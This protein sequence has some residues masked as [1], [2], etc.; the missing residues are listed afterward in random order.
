MKINDPMSVDPAASGLEAERGRLRRLRLVALALLLLAIAGMLISAHFG[1]SGPWGWS[2][3]FCEAAAVG[4]L[5]D[6]F[7]VTALF[8]RPLGLPIPHTDV[9]AKRKQEIGNGLAD[10]VSEHFLQ[11]TQLALKLREQAFVLRFADHLVQPSAARRV[12]DHARSYALG[13]YD[14]LSGTKLESMIAEMLRTGLERLDFG[15]MT[16]NWLDLLTRDGRHHEVLD[17]FLQWL[18]EWLDD[19]DI[20]DRI[21]RN[22]VAGIENKSGWWRALNKVGLADLI[23]GEITDSL[24]AMIESLQDSLRDPAHPNREAFDEWL[25]GAIDRLQ[26]DPETQAWL[27]ERIRTFTAAP[28][29]HDYLGGIG[30]DVRGWLRAD[31]EREDSM[32]AAWLANGLSGLARR[33]QTDRELR[34]DLD[35]LI[36]RLAIVL[37]PSV[38]DFIHKHIRETV[39]NWN[40]RDLISTLE[41][42]LGPDLQFIRFNGTLA[43]GLIGLFLHALLVFTLPLLT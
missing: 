39:R 14:A 30:R 12:A 8:R 34:E 40:E 3:A 1:G 22:I 15:R 31:L 29:F 11:P 10:F 16:G 24:P 28:E 42:K 21:F 17:E 23:S 6:W 25:T 43:G 27:N 20:K 18:A 4:A 32:L 33:L 9:L 41:L 19:E 7:A 2:L 35:G 5:A 26:K 38:D 36:E 13:F 37:A